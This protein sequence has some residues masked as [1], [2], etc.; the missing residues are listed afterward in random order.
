MACMGVED[1]SCK[2]VGQL[3]FSLNLIKLLSLGLFYIEGNQKDNT[4]PLRCR[5]VSCE[6]DR[7]FG[8]EIYWPGNL[9]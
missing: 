1:C 2:G 9:L 3:T 8:R 6:M 5:F 4:G 7:N